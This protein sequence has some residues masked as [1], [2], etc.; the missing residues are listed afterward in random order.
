MSGKA[1]KI[2]VTEKQ[3]SV[4]QRIANAANIRGPEVDFDV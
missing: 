4:L 2:I 1:A 3:Q